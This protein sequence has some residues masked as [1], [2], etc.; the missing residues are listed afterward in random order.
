MKVTETGLPGV[1]IVEPR[2]FVDDRGLFLETYHAERYAAEKFGFRFVQ[3]NLSFSRQG[4]LRGLHYQLGRPQGKLVMVVQGE[5]YDVAV[6]IRKGS[7]TFGRWSGT[8]L[9]SRNYRQ[10]FVPEG[11]AHGFSVQSETATV[12]YK[13]TDFYSPADERGIRWD[14]PSLGIDWPV[15]NP[16]LS[17]KDGTYPTLE[18]IPAHDLPEFRD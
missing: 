13:C 12:M 18:T 17:E 7:P 9:S 14:D 8:V 16:I 11:F 15:R 5:V 10:V 2:L 3:D 6:D 1:L 4:V